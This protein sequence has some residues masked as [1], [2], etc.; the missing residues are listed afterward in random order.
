[1]ND[2]YQIKYPP[3]ST[4]S[5]HSHLLTPTSIEGGKARGGAKGGGGRHL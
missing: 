3:K 2:P 5:T 4:Q 1:M